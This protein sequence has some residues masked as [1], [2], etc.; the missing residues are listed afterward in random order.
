[1]TTSRKRQRCPTEGLYIAAM[2][3]AVVVS[4]ASAQSLR[5]VDAQLAFQAQDRPVH[6]D[7]YGGRHRFG[8][9][10]DPNVQFDMMRQRNWRKG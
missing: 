6:R 4:P 5:G 1:M 3:V 10:P 7:V 2:V 8:T 9:D